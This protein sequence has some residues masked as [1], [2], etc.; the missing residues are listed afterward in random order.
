MFFLIREVY[1]NPITDEVWNE[2]DLIPEPTLARTLDI[3]AAEGPEAIHNGTLTIPL[4]ED[5]V[6]FGGI[7]TEEDLRHY[8]CVLHCFADSRMG[9]GIFKLRYA[10]KN[11]PMWQCGKVTFNFSLNIKSKLI[12][13]D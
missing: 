1:V 9:V 5:I 2:G 13:L 11:K 4:V 7:V 6:A 8:R 3:I 10:N 12:L